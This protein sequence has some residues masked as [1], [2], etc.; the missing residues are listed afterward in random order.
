MSE[1]VL[2]LRKCVL[3]PTESGRVLETAENVCY[4]LPPP[5]E[6]GRLLEATENW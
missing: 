4:Y 2:I 6:P 3:L 5:I 1:C